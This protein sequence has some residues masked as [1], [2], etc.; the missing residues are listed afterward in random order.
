[1]SAEALS[2]FELV[3]LARLT[4]GALISHLLREIAADLIGEGA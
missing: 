4:G 3:R 1:M 2:L